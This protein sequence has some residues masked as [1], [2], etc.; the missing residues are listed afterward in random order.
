VREGERVFVWIA[1]FADR[2]HGDATLQALMRS[3]Q[4][5][6]QIVPAARTGGRKATQALR[7]GGDAAVKLLRG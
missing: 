3:A 2:Q 1:R 4:W 6:K 5:R 7:L